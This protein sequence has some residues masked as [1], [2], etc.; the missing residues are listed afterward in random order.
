[1]LK[2]ISL[3]IYKLLIFYFQNHN[4]FH[5]SLL[6]SMKNDFVDSLNLILVNDIKK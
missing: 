1:M 2:F 4:V 3:Q 6:K 5:I